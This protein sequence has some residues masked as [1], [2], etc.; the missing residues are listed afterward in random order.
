MKLDNVCK[1]LTTHH[2]RSDVKQKTESFLYYL[3]VQVVGYGNGDSLV[4][5]YLLPFLMITFASFS[6]L[7]Y[8]SE[9][10]QRLGSNVR[11]L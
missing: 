9:S 4:C 8:F 1:I 6:M 2:T 5:M 7:D 3:P 11:D 10:R